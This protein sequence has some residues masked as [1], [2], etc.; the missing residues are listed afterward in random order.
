M[1]QHTV[2]VAA[3]PDEGTRAHVRLT[4][5]SERY[6]VREAA[7][8]DGTIEAIARHHPALLVL[9][10]ALPGAGALAI[11]RTVRE[12]PDTASIRTL[13]VA[14]RDELPEGADGVDATLGLPAT[15]LSLL[16][17]VEELLHGA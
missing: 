1:A 15:S 4:L 14:R 13:L 16:Q 12:Q 10:L 2:V 6:V 17:K 9:D 11:A 7:D 8:T 5:G 3:S